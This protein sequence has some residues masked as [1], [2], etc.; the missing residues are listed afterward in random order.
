VHQ[1]YAR[2]RIREGNGDATEDAF[3][4]RIFV[5]LESLGKD[6]KKFELVESEKNIQTLRGRLEWRKK[7]SEVSNFLEHISDVI[8]NEA[9]DRWVFNYSLEKGRLFSIEYP[10]WDPTAENF[11]ETQ[12]EIKS[13]VVCY[14]TEENTACIFHLMRIAEI[15]L[16]VLAR[17]RRVSIP[18]KPLEWAEWNEILTHLRK[19]VEKIAITRRGKEKDAALEFYRGALGEFESFKDVYRNNVMHVRKRYDEHQAAS[20]LIHVREF[21]NRLAAKLNS[22]SKTQIRWG[23]R[24]V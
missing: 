7:F 20:A 12:P 11:K 16:R 21:M 3:L 22:E 23:L 17:E 6:C 19:E 14:A 10:K 2:D 5:T 9:G 1:E 4:E 8:Q 15:G 24:K 18:K 13:A